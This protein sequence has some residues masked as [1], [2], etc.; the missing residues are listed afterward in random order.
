MF[1]I[2]INWSCKSFFRSLVINTSILRP[3]KKASLPQI[4]AVITERSTTFVFIVGQHLQ[5]F[6]FSVSKR[7]NIA[8]CFEY[9]FDGIKGIFPDFSSGRTFL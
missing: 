6:C 5:K 4:L 9:L 7:K 1:I 8:F 3:L 2:W